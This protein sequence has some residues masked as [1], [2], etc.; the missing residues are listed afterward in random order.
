MSTTYLTRPVLTQEINCGSPLTKTFAYDLRQLDLGQSGRVYDALQDHVAQ[1][2]EVQVD[3]RS[4]A[5]IQAWD[6]FFTATRGQM[7]G[8]WLPSN[9][10]EMRIKAN[11]SGTQFSITHANLAD[12]YADHPS[13]YLWFTKSGQPPKGAKISGVVEV[14]ATTERV[15]VDASVSVDETWDVSLLHYVR[16]ASAEEK[17]EVVAEQWQTRRVRVVEIPTEYAAMETG[18]RPVFFYKFWIE[19]PTGTQYW[20][21]TSFD[22]TISAEGITWTPEPI[23]HGQLRQS[24]RAD[25][26]EVMVQAYWSAA[27][28]LKL[29]VP[30]MLPLPLKV[31]IT[32][33]TLPSLTTQ[34]VLFQGEVRSVKP[35]GKFLEARCSSFLDALERR[36]PSF[37]IQ[38]TCNYI[39]FEPNTCKAVAATY[40]K[41][42]TITTITRDVIRVSDASLTGLGTGWF[43]GGWLQMGTGA[44]LEYRAIMDS[45]EIGGGVH[46]LTMNQRLEHGAVSD[47][48]TLYPGCDR[49]F[50]TCGSKFS[51]GDNFGGFPFMPRRNPALRAKPI[52]EIDGKK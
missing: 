51:N 45:T 52:D 1:G 40:A 6:D 7:T 31:R 41:T 4:L 25:R 26:E 33:R 15:T 14:D 36:L 28:P 2:F 11:V 43:A 8:F 10:V 30:F 38:K 5:E 44:E 13:Q 32:K 42:A 35:K 34:K 3:L 39:L 17:A 24:A 12:W 47:A 20:Y 22:Q 46:E 23:A 48:A 49:T 9:R 16:L 50:A 19:Y 21:F 37:L 27:T 29:F 18:Q